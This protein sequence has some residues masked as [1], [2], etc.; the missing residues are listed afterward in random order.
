MKYRW[1]R[2]S[3]FT[4]HCSLITNHYSLSATCYVL[5]IHFTFKRDLVYPYEKGD[6]RCIGNDNVSDSHSLINRIFNV[7][8][9]L[10]GENDTKTSLLHLSF[11]PASRNRLGTYS[12]IFHEC[13]Y[14]NS[15][16]VGFSIKTY[17][18]KHFK[19]TFNI[20]CY[21]HAHHEEV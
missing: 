15:N 21:I 8:L 17:L 5:F 13:T 4:A 10:I 19:S 14:S 3:P 11:R 12:Q 18:S 16:M 9:D 20:F 2:H 1:L 6:S 7:I